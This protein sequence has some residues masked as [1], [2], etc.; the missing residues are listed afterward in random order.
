MYNGSRN[1]V[2]LSLWFFRKDK[3]IGQIFGSGFSFVEAFDAA[4]DVYNG[5]SS[6]NGIL[7]VIRAYAPCSMSFGPC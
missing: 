3:L 2:L 5:V 1:A 4:A 7:G 6:K